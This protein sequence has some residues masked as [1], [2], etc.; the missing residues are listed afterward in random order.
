M[1]IRF[2]AAALA[3]LLC[4]FLPPESSALP[5]PSVMA[6]GDDAASRPDP[7]VRIH[8]SAFP[9][10]GLRLAF[11]RDQC[12][13]ARNHPP[14]FY[15]PDDFTPVLGENTDT[16]FLLVLDRSSLAVKRRT[17]Y[18]ADP[19]ELALL[20]QDLLSLKDGSAPDGTPWRDNVLAVV[21]GW[22][23]RVDTD[24]APIRSGLGAIGFQAGLAPDD[25]FVIIGIPG[26]IR[27]RAW[28]RIGRDGGTAMLD[29]YLRKAAT[30]HD[31]N[32]ETGYVFTDGV[33][34]PFH[35]R[36]EDLPTRN[37]VVVGGS[38]A[39]ADIPESGGL[40][41]VRFDAGNLAIRENTV[42]PTDDLDWE[43]LA[44]GM[45]DALGDGD[46]IVLATLGDPAAYATP[47]HPAHF[48]RVMKALE[49][50]GV[51]PDIFARSLRDRRPY[52]MIA[53]GGVGYAS[54]AVMADGFWNADQLP[55]SRGAVS[56]VLER[57]PD[58]SVIPAAGDRGGHQAPELLPILLENRVSWPFT[59]NMG[60]PATGPEIALAWLA[61]KRLET[62]GGLR[63]FRR[64]P[65]EGPCGA[66]MAG[67][68]LQTADG[69]GLVYVCDANVRRAALDWRRQYAS[70]AD[71]PAY[72]A[73]QPEYHDGLPFTG[74]GDVADCLHTDLAAAVRQLNHELAL[75]S[76]IRTFFDILR[77]PVG[78]GPSRTGGRYRDAAHAI[79]NGALAAP[80]GAVKLMSN[81]SFF[82]IGI[83]GEAPDVLSRMADAV[84][85]R[86]GFGKVARMLAVA[87]DAGRA[88]SFHPMGIR[89]VG[90]ALA[91]FHV[92]SSQ[93]RRKAVD[94]DTQISDALAQQREGLDLAEA[95]VLSDWGRMTAV[96]QQ[97]A[98]G[99]PWDIRGSETAVLDAMVAAYAV[100][101]RRQTWY[102]YFGRFYQM[103][104][105][106][107][108][109]RGPGPGAQ[110]VGD[111]WCRMGFRKDHAS[112][113][114]GA[115]HPFRSS[116]SATGLG[117]DPGSGGIGDGQGYLPLNYIFSSGKDRALAAAMF[118][119]SWDGTPA[120][121]GIH[122]AQGLAGSGF[123]HLVSTELM[124]TVMQAPDISDPDDPSGGFYP[125]EFWFNAVAPQRLA[126]NSAE[127]ENRVRIKKKG[128]YDSVPRFWF[129]VDEAAIG[130]LADSGHLRPAAAD[131][132]G[133][134]D[135]DA[136]FG[137][138]SGKTIFLRNDGSRQGLAFDGPMVDAFGLA[139]VDGM[140]SPAFADL[141][142]DGD[143]D[144]VVGEQ[145]GRMQYFRNDGSASAPW[146]AVSVPGAFGL[147]PVDGMA[148]PAFADLDGDGDL[149]ALVGDQSG[150]MHYFR[151]DGSPADPW[152]AAAVPDPF[153]LRPVDGMASPAFHDMDGDGD[154]DAFVGAASGRTTFYRNIGTATA[155]WMVRAGGPDP[156]GLGGVV[157]MAAPALA[158][159]DGDGDADLLMGAGTGS[160]LLA[161][162]EVVSP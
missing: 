16:V 91:D 136:F 135:A 24:W 40:Q 94:I 154:L 64:S 149:D 140:A 38:T 144:A 82:S 87:G 8:I 153:G 60:D 30:V 67:R 36:A 7:L 129:D 61:E 120:N 155:P 83:F 102:A 118:E 112:G 2:T 78:Q 105:A 132:D 35:T 5:A 109:W 23:V 76:Q 134:G 39:A 75:R 81:S 130:P 126:C 1:K 34:A 20:N 151:N 128:I 95:A 42:F 137:E 110:G 70:T 139:P 33:A 3:A 131:I 104:V 18:T 72:P 73:L 101:V 43:V 57:G 97:L 98:P 28:H 145:S 63:L 162:N 69:T 52:S 92:L 115:I 156:F 32:V 65:E 55:V 74:C 27:G 46:G 143:L 111:W 89:P 99:G 44:E 26:M 85:E 9:G 122:D 11:N 160:V 41:L 90:K 96:G 58:G 146:F 53:A 147:A 14:C 161:W 116:G 45:E 159:M 124:N 15:G 106:A 47:R 86:V 150:R 4:F 158:D 108:C 59:P 84:P 13:N 54:S 133:D 114:T 138:A 29:G 50:A 125:P 123:R 31:G 119:K 88:G 37:I 56:G 66:D 148:S 80:E 51:H 117:P 157:Q 71:L 25:N 127:H 77:R 103:G 19:A 121:T 12:G 6:G 10:Q 113:G 141:D 93:R 49:Q 79:V 17:R 22:P 107:A 68:P 142:G 21:T 48:L 100:G 62:D 152:F